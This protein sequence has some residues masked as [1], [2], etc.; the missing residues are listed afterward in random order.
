MAFH[1][2]TSGCCQLPYR[3][4]LDNEDVTSPKQFVWV[5]GD[6]RPSEE[7]DGGNAVTKRFYAQGE[8]IGG[9]NYYYTKDHLGSIR[10]MTDSSGVIDAR[11]DYDPYGR[12]TKLRG[13][14][15]ADFGF[16]RHYCH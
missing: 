6:T 4:R 12:R 2:G 5:P 13:D 1:W 16:T 9:A 15:D 14:L 8:Q 11:Y 7:R 10:E 3:D